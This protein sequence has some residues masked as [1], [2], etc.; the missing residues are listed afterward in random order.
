MIELRLFGGVDLR[1]SDGHQLDAVL[2]QPK[3]VALLAFLAA[4]TPHRFHR[5]D[6][7]LA[8]FWPE[9]DQ[10]HARAALRQA[11]HSLR[12]AFDTEVLTSRGDEEVGL[13]E[14][15][16]WCDVRAFRQALDEGDV[17]TG[18]ELYRGGLLEGF[19]L[20]GS[21]E[22][23]RWL[24]AERS[25]LRDRACN[26]A[27]ALAERSRAEG[28]ARRAAHWVRR[29]ASLVPEN[30]EMLRRVITLL[31]ELGDRVGA[32]QVYEEFA[33]RAAG[34]Y[35]V[36]PA[37]ETKA[38]IASVRSREASSARILTSRQASVPVPGAAPVPGP[39]VAQPAP[40]AFAGTGPERPR[41]PLVRWVALG[42]I[43]L[44]GGGIIARRLLRADP[45]A[46]RPSVGIVA[47]ENRSVGDTDA[48]L[49]GTFTEGVTQS[50][51]AA[52][53]V[54]VSRLPRGGRGTQYLLTGSMR[55]TRDTV[56]VAAELERAGSG[57]ILW[58][59]RLKVGDASDLP[60]TIAAEVLTALGVPADRARARANPD[61]YGLYLR[62]R[63]Q[64]SRR[65]PASLA[66]AVML[67]DQSIRRD[68][69]L[70]RGWAGL[71][72]ALHFAN[73][74]RAP[75]PGVPRDSLLA[76]EIRASERAV[77]L[78]S[79]DVEVW[80]T[81]ALVSEDLDPTSRAPALHAIR[82]ALALDSLNAEAWHRLA[83]ALEETGDRNGAGLAWR[84]AVA[85]D[86]GHLEAMAFL[87]L[88]YWWWHVYDSA[89]VWADSVVA[90]D[91][92]YLLGR[93]TAGQVALE[94]GRR[95]EAE[96]Q[97]S[98][99]L[100]LALGPTNAGLSGLVSLA[101]AAGDRAR[102]QWL[103]RTA[104]ARTD[105]S[106]PDVHGAVNI[107][108]GFVAIGDFDRAL[109]WLE[110]YR[111]MRDL[112]FQLHLRLDPPLDPLRRYPRFQALLV[113]VS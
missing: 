38:L 17:T 85:L 90:T 62:G 52:H 87:A 2:T 89:A 59:T 35:A 106:D 112:H 25:R 111:P 57:E 50:L 84:Q 23:E 8:L 27:W 46:S 76:R 24:E 53:S 96:A 11:L 30:E 18:L 80:L 51:V 34:E 109:R 28:D 72:R 79:A 20:S 60:D 108:A 43:L 49:I 83:F 3:R 71:A 45:G 6:T 47:F 58:A 95:D 22:F 68:S 26:A 44:L 93:V 94:R 107:A 78:D 21:P 88:H 105:S 77:E 113:R 1:R 9:L 64:I 97:L 66:R 73:R 16:L 42:M 65:T 70:A 33:K 14:R 61:A 31:D 37:A 86:P 75:I 63:D 55:R 7:L 99:V 36:E 5:R 92:T 98:T 67:L 104:E 13:E 103:L 81:R 29:A 12:R 110:R 10:V 40:L 54:Q 102:A 15:A 91:P 32:V 19:F 100:P 4:A 82:R 48:T 39:T 41:M 74:L 101:V 69:T 56:E